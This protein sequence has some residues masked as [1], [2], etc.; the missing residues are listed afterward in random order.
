MINK[1]IDYIKKNR[2]S[3]TEIADCM[4]KIGLL[5]NSNILN[6][7]HFKVG[8]VHYCYCDDE[9]NWNVHKYIQDLEENCVVLVDDLGSEDRGIFGDLI[10]KYLFLYKQ[11]SAIVTNGNIRDTHALV[12]ENYPIWSK[13]SNPVGC[14]NIEPKN[15]VNIDTLKKR[16]EYFQGSIAVCDDTGVVIITKEYLTEEFYK[17]LE[18]I[19][20]QE[21]LWF[22]CID[23]K[24]WNTF[25]TVCLK[26]YKNT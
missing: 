25:E 26:K 23:R 1:I 21:D 9:S 15:P 22:D 18:W 7:K 11:S 8:K 17:K 4:G 24:K 14:F 20:E 3:T 16:Q 13:G 6:N 12:K 19:E 10:S 2:V 5:K